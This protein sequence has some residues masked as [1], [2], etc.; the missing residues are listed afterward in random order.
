[1]VL[2]VWLV[3]KTMVR[4]RWRCV[5]VESGALSVITTGTG[6][7]LQWSVNSCDTRKQVGCDVLILPL[8][9]VSALELGYCIIIGTT[10]HSFAGFGLTLLRAV[11][12]KYVAMYLEKIMVIV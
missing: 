7:M 9:T 12:L 11:I 10:I 6:M 5:I 1:M 2:F 4:G 8:A 3:G